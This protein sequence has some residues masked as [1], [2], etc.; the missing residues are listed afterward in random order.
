MSRRYRVAIAAFALLFPAAFAAAQV[1]GMALSFSLVSDATLASSAGSMALNLSAGSGNAQA[2]MVAIGM[3]NGLSA[4][5]IDSRQQANAISQGVRGTELAE[6]GARTFHDASGIVALNQV[7]GNANT[8]ANLVAIAIGNVS[9]VAIDQLGSV[10]A[11]PDGSDVTVHGP[12]R[13]SGAFISDSA[14][15]A[16]HGIVQVNQLAGFGNSTANIFALSVSV[17]AQQ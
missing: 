16:A 1:L 17:G 11:A 14:F 5:V 2:N 10:S 7:S 3:G 12:G 8:Q 15:A 6:I 13:W 9:E 4:A